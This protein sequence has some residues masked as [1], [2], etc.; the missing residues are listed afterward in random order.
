MREMENVLRKAAA[1]DED[2]QGKGKKDAR[3]DTTED[4][5]SFHE[6]DYD[7]NK[8]DDD[9]I[10]KNC[11]SIVDRALEQQISNLQSKS[12]AD[13]KRKMASDVK[14]KNATDVKDKNAASIEGKGASEKVG[15]Q[16]S[17][18]VD[19]HINTEEQIPINKESDSMST[20]EFNGNSYSLDE[21]T[22]VKK[23]Q[24]VRFRLERDMKD[25]KFF[26]GST[27]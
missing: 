15:I 25:P 12:A 2:E 20:E 10:Y 3:L 27:F 7:F 17:A 21:D 1:F 6:S 22:L 14:G 23:P 11:I 13:E 26:C 16:D 8:N 9:A 24:Y 4:C 5:E 19:F 18:Y